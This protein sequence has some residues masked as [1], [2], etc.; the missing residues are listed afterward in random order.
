M[1]RKEND[2]KKQSSDDLEQRKDKLT[3]DQ[4]RLLELLE[5]QQQQA[6]ASATTQETQNFN[7]AD[8]HRYTDH[9][10]VG[11]PFPNFNNPFVQPIA[12]QNNNFNMNV[13]NPWQQL[14]Q[15]RKLD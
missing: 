14:M 11:N 12:S 3:D 4:L 1:A 10:G 5:Q 9:M 13:A 7:Q 15:L 6:G 8:E 2:E